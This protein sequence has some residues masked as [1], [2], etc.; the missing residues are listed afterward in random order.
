MFGLDRIP[1]MSDD[2][3]VF[4]SY[5]YDSDE[6]RQWVLRLATALDSEPGVHVTFD[7]F[8]LYPGK[9]LTYFMDQALLCSRIIIVSTPNYLLKAAE[10]SGGVGYETSIIT[11]ELA[12]D[13]AQDKFIPVL[14]AGD[15]LPPFLKS[16]VRIDLRE[17]RPFDDGLADLLAA[18][19][20]QAAAARPA[21]RA[22]APSSAAGQPRRPTD[23]TD[24][25]EALEG[26][27]RDDFRGGSKYVHVLPPPPPRRIGMSTFGFE[28]SGGNNDFALFMENTGDDIL[29]NVKVAVEYEQVR[30]FV[31]ELS[32]L[33]PGQRE[34]IAL[35]EG[36]ARANI[37]AGPLMQ[38]LAQ[39]LSGQVE[40]N[41]RNRILL[42]YVDSSGREHVTAFLISRD[43]KKGTPSLIRAD[44]R[45]AS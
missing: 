6:H 22:A 33:T 28:W 25:I 39:V 41:L 45:T 4:M 12:R 20:R 8:D 30:S 7:Q 5:S 26:L 24:P 31:M 13:Q 27:K 38:H 14:R 2:I 42:F 10:R 1:F 23:G 37:D 16:K 34:R 43:R 36:A 11:A 17:P 3:T 18:L 9:D 15:D 32:D 40:P 21:K 44:V 29:T 19:K 35:T